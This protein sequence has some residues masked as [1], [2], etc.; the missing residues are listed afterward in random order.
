MVDKDNDRP[1]RLHFVFWFGGE[2]AKHP[3]D[4]SFFWL[5]SVELFNM[6]SSPADVMSFYMQYLSNCVFIASPPANALR[7]VF[8]NE[9]LGQSCS[10]GNFP[11][12]VFPS[13]S[14]FCCD[15]FDCSDCYEC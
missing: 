12:E 8:L 15:G 13:R 10:C 5:N 11:V 4:D 7:D 14:L 9:I 1:E 6:A 3:I 2:E